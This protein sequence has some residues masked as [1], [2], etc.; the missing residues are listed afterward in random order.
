M[1]KM[2]RG[3]ITKQEVVVM[4]GDDD[5]ESE[6]VDDVVIIL[7]PPPVVVVFTTLRVSSCP[8]AVPHP[9]SPPALQLFLINIDI[10]SSSQ[11][12]PFSS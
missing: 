1:L 2:V 4:M 10:S 11:P 3:K 9:P 8:S 12:N 7:S 6:E 5:A